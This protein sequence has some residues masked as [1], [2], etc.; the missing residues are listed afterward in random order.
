MG[1][2]EKEM[3]LKAGVNRAKV[4]M[5]RLESNRGQDDVP[6]RR[7]CWTKAW[8][9]LEAWHAFHGNEDSSQLGNLENH[10]NQLE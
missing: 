2:E 6:W 7:L 3:L 10:F 9:A 4:K 5:Q 8:H 1:W